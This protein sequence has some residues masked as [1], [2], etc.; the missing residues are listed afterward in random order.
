[1][2]KKELLIFDLDGTLVDT[3]QDIT[4]SVNYAR[5][6]LG[7][8]ALEVAT[9]MQG[10]GDGLRKLMERSLPN[11]HQAKVEEAV[12]LFRKHYDEHALDFTALYPGVDETLRHFRDKKLAVLSNKPVSFCRS[13]MRGLEIES[14]FDLILGGDSVVAMKPSPEPILVVLRRLEVKPGDA[15]MIGDGTTD[16]EAG[17]QAH[18][19]TCAVTY[20]FR[21]PAILREA[22]PDYLIEDIRALQWIFC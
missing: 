15:A 21:E 2:L 16:I 22:Q 20:G 12:A 4:N 18:L 8:P 7:L 14:F 17:K 13:I 19:T 1:M 11:E 9:V 3:S 6:Q 5:A 10:V